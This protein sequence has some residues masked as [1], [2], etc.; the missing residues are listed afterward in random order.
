MLIFVSNT[1][2]IDSNRFPIGR[3]QGSYLPSCW[4]RSDLK[5]V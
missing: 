4:I 2:I 5:M 1:I 3:A